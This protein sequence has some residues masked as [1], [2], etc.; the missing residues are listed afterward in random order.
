MSEKILLEKYEK[1][2]Q[3]RELI[4]TKMERGLIYIST[5]KVLGV[6]M[7]HLMEIL[8]EPA[9]SLIYVTKDLALIVRKN[10]E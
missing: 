7:S 5:F 1:T 3:F 8:S 6:G 9:G 2:W 4:K 10:M